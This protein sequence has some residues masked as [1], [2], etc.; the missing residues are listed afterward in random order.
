M[1]LDTRARD[2]IWPESIEAAIPSEERI[3]DAVARLESAGVKYLFSCWIDLQGVPKTKPVP[4]SE[5]KTLC[6]GRG[7]QFGVHS[8]SMVPELGPADPDQIAIPDLDSLRICPWDK[9]IA[10]VFADL[11]FKDAPYNVCPRLVLKRQVQAAAAAGYKVLAGLEP[12]FMVMRYA[13]DGR[14]VKAIDDD[15][16]TAG[17]FRPRRQAFGYD[18]EFSFDGMPFLSNVMEMFGELGWDMKN[19]VCEGAYSQFELDFGYTD[20]IG[21]ADRFVFLRVMLKELAKRHG[22]FVTFMPKP[23][24]GDWRN[25]AHINHSVQ[26]T[27]RP[28][29]NLFEAEDGGWSDYALHS[30]GGLIA[31][32]G[33]LTA[34][35][36]STVNSYKGLIGRAAG[37]EGGTLTWAPTH[38]CYGENNR[39]AMFRLPQPR[40][41]IENR[42]ADMC[43]N[44]YL[45]LAM[46]SAAT[47]EGILGKI[48]PGPAVTKSLYDTPATELAASKIKRLPTNLLEAVQMFEED[49]LAKDVLGPTM[50]G[51]FSRLKRQEWNRFHEHV[52]EWE[53]LEYLRF[54]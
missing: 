36:C 51:M 11:F 16:F 23:T 18:A 10:W 6:L 31:H 35:A 21:M 19:V 52:T 7:P 54:F 30:L 26:Q 15:P 49:G 50:H 42:A 8:V 25:G 3:A 4:V 29:V 53:R 47:L 13:A 33:A 2:K 48:N 44:V 9:S 46:T 28:G 17:G 38:M 24:Q 22:L 45:T 39:S 34:L 40:R 43:Q 37:L 27:S 14:P 20:L 32:G 12:E 41:A 5:L 1:V